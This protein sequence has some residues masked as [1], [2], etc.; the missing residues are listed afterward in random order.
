MIDY[1]TL[2]SFEL[3]LTD[4]SQTDTRRICLSCTPTTRSHCNS[5]SLCHRPNRCGGN[6][7]LERG[8][9]CFRQRDCGPHPGRPNQVGLQLQGVQSG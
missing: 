9:R 7:T 1:Y 2:D 5:Y 3:S 8:N 4:P 6:E